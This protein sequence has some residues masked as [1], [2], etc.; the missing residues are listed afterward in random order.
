[1]PGL[2]LLAKS[3]SGKL[4]QVQVPADATIGMAKREI[5]ARLLPSLKDTLSV[6]MRLRGRL[7]APDDALLRDMG[8]TSNQ[9]LHI[10]TDATL[11]DAASLAAVQ[12]GGS[13]LRACPRGDGDDRDT[14]DC[15]DFTRIGMNDTAV[16]FEA[17]LQRLASKVASAAELEESTRAEMQ[18]LQARQDDLLDRFARIEKAMSKAN[19]GSDMI[20]TFATKLAAIENKPAGAVTHQAL[21]PDLVIRIEKLEKLIAS[22]LAKE[23]QAVAPDLAIRVEKL[24]EKLIAS[25]VND[26]AVSGA[27]CDAGVPGLQEKWR[28]LRAQ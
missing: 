15:T 18:R 17:E 19:E 27:P 5:A 3:K 11:D 28:A 10:E 25:I 4:A 2:V 24:E 26:S 1:M 13:P 7:L 6:S 8:V 20:K 22:V 12:L 23:P 16:K 9:L 21:A 14:G